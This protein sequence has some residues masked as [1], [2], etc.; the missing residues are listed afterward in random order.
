LWFGKIFEGKHC[1]PDENFGNDP[2]LEG[3]RLLCNA[4]Q[5]HVSNRIVT[6]ARQSLESVRDV[7][8]VLADGGS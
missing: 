5:E 1:E 7:W 3:T 2:N 8:D 4:E 6:S